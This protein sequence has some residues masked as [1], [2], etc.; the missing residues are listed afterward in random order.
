M[1][2]NLKVREALLQC[3]EIFRRI[4]LR[5][6]NPHVAIANEPKQLFREKEEALKAVDVDY[7]LSKDDKRYI[8]RFF[9]TPSICSWQ[10]TERIA[11]LLGAPCT[12]DEGYVNILVFRKKVDMNL[13]RDIRKDSSKW[14][15][16]QMSALLALR[17]E[18]HSLPVGTV[19]QRV[20]EEVRQMSYA[21]W[22]TMNESIGAFAIP[23]DQVIV[24]TVYGPIDE[25]RAAHVMT[26]DDED[27][28]LKIRVDPAILYPR[29]YEQRECFA[30]VKSKWMHE[31]MC[32]S[33]G[34]K[35]EQLTEIVYC[36]TNALFK[37]FPQIRIWIDGEYVC[38]TAG[39][40]IVRYKNRRDP[41]HAATE[42]LIML[43]ELAAAESTL[44]N[45]AD[46]PYTVQQNGNPMISVG[47][48]DAPH[49]YCNM[50]TTLGFDPFL[51]R[52][53]VEHR[54]ELNCVF[55]SLW[56]WIHQ[57]NKETLDIVVRMINVAVSRTYGTSAT[58]T[59]LAKTL[60][61]IMYPGKIQFSVRS[62]KEVSLCLDFL[63]YPHDIFT[64]FKRWWAK[65]DVLLGYNQPIGHRPPLSQVTTRAFESMYHLMRQNLKGMV[66]MSQGVVKMFIHA[67][68]SCGQQIVFFQ[69]L[70]G[71][72]RVIVPRVYFMFHDVPVHFMVRNVS[73][74][75]LRFRL[76]YDYPHLF[77]KRDE[78]YDTIFAFDDDVQNQQ[79]MRG[80]A[81]I[82]VTFHLPRGYNMRQLWLLVYSSERLI[83]VRP[84][85]S[86]N[87]VKG[88][89]VTRPVFRCAPCRPVY[90]KEVEV[91]GSNYV[92]SSLFFVPEEWPDEFRKR[93]L[94]LAYRSDL[95]GSWRWDSS[96]DALL[97]LEDEW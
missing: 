2:N 74:K 28:P 51:T 78:L 17:K 47:T 65:Y 68:L 40:A 91:L 43:F 69:N 56:G 34:I 32:Y 87:G 30:V 20:I 67:Q 13:Q 97:M 61:A 60:R 45:H 42:A 77:E 71:D 21:V 33:I 29:H 4:V 73:D 79:I 81:D 66:P 89:F 72:P 39:T 50:I 96:A 59:L 6:G 18:W 82:C 86:V 63:G 48:P 92:R 62:R 11:F 84:F 55:A 44:L 23:S 53:V 7:Y 93:W 85:T 25:P 52:L 22:E 35:M 75:E 76:S 31:F 36:Y 37:Y 26:I 58:I 64:V 38:I 95:H 46:F 49:I 24:H 3:S 9:E 8:R 88:N 90:L 80:A 70:D 15:A 10:R 12:E 19:L 14:H 83:A 16:M 1:T 41:V 57:L 27:R 54:P 94:T 5:Y